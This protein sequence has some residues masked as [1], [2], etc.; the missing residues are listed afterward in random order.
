MPQMIIKKNIL[1]VLM[2]MLGVLQFPY[3]LTY[4]FTFHRN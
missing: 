4:H 2:K 1:F 3:K